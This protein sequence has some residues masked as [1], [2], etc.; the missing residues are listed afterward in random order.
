MKLG[1]EQQAEVERELKRL[2]RTSPQSAE[3]QVIRTF[4]EWVTE[5]PWSIRSEDKI[6]LALSTEILDEDHYGLEDV[7]DRVLEFLAVRKLQLDRFEDPGDG[8]AD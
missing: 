2:E 4:L 6:D 8:T 3:Y 1:E 5:L 7:K